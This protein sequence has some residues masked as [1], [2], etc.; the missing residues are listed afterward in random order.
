M[1]EELDFGARLHAAAREAGQEIVI[2]HRH[3]LLTSDR[4]VRLY[5]TWEHIR[6]LLRVAVSPRATM[7]NRS[8][9]HAWYD[10]RR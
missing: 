6:F 8:A 3:P 5:S 2:L 9:C 10:G 1:A 7:R 4:K